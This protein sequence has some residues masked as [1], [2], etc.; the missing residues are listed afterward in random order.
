MEFV[1]L[2]FWL[3]LMLFI[4]RLA[5]LVLQSYQQTFR[6]YHVKKTSINR[7]KSKNKRI[8]QNMRP[9]GGRKI[10]SRQWRELLR[11]VHGDVATANRLIDCELKRNPGRSLDWCLDKALWQLQ[12]DRR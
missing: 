6:H 5:Y 2:F 9:S 7:H 4:L 1:I 11:L 3:I 12:R 8:F 10:N